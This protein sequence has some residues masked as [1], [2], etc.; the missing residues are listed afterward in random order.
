MSPIDQW[1]RLDVS[2]FLALIVETAFLG[3]FCSLLLQTV[4]ALA[5][6]AKQR[7]STLFSPMLLTALVLSLTITGNWLTELKEAYDAFILPSNPSSLNHS[8][9]SHAEIAYLTLENP[10]N[11]ANSALYVVST[12]LGDGFMIY[13]LYIVWARNKYIIIPPALMSMSLAVTGSM[14]TYLFSRSAEAPIFATAGAWITASFTLTLIC[15]L[16]STSLIA[17]KIYLSNRRLARLH[18]Q[19]VGFNK[20]MEILVQSAALYSFCL[21]LSLATYIAS[22]N[23]VLITVGATN[24]IIVRFSFQCIMAITQWIS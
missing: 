1:P 4:Q 20:I 18:T 7:Q 24:P 22:S 17:F 13:R 23:L 19:R 8:G 12:L 10:W 11:V 2:H 16:Y 9:L 6:R 14:V 21:I 5:Y 15:N 3:F